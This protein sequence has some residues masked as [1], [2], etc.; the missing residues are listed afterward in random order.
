MKEIKIYTTKRKSI[1]LLIISA[2][3]ITLNCWFF[4][5]ANDIVKSHHTLAHFIK[6]IS[7][8]SNILWTTCAFIAYK[9]I[10]R[11]KL[12]IVLNT[13][14]IYLKLHPSY[15]EYIPWAKVNGFEE[16]NFNGNKTLGI[17]I[18]NPKYHLKDDPNLVIR[19]IK[20]SNMKTVGLPFQISTSKLTVKHNTLKKL[21]LNYY[22]EYKVAS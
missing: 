13:K 5:Y 19:Q 9:N 6:L 7:I 10:T 22:T 14:G 3:F 11:H 18:N 1:H 4:F 8:C 2:S 15:T 17:V 16:I 20:E 12:A 21:L